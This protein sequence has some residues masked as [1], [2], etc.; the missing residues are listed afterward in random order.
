MFDN[1]VLF[2]ERVKFQG[3]GPADCKWSGE[4]P[5][6]T[7]VIS[8]PTGFDGEAMQVGVPVYKD[9]TADDLALRFHALLSL[10]D[11]RMVENNLALL[12]AEELTKEQADKKA[13]EAQT[14]SAMLV[15]AKKAAKAGKVAE[16]AA[17]A[18][19]KIEQVADN[20]GSP[21]QS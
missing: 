16:V 3:K 10:G 19:G 15:A 18:G 12:K 21:E 17:I 1:S 2:P 9:D 4:T 14:R 5:V 11:A 20:S 13:F 8:K 7:I 6:T